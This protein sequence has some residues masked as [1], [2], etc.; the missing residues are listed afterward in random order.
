VHSVLAKGVY[1]DANIAAFKGK[2]AGVDAAGW[3]C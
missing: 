1:R 3:Y 2:R